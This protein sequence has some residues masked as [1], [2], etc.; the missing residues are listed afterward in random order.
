[1]E[2]SVWLM[3]AVKLRDSEEVLWVIVYYLIRMQSVV[4]YV[5]PQIFYMTSQW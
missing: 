5:S 2:E 3:R 4:L 1:M